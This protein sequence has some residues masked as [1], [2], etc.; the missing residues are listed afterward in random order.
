MKCRVSSLLRF[1]A[2]AICRTIHSILR[3]LAV[4][5][6]LHVVTFFSAVGSREAI[7][8]ERR[9]ESRGYAQLSGDAVEGHH[10][11]SCWG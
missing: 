10:V 4:R 9:T 7:F 3:K 5:H 1:G 2:V 6:D 8:A 11:D